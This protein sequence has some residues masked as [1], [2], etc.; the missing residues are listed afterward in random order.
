GTRRKPNL[1]LPTK[2]L[3]TWPESSAMPTAYLSRQNP[4]FHNR[5]LEWPVSLAKRALMQASYIQ[6]K[7]DRMLCFWALKFAPKAG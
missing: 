3:E 4:F 7:V 2:Q 6:S 5:W 1:G